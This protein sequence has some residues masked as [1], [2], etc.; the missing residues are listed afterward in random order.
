MPFWFGFFFSRVLFS[1]IIFI[2]WGFDSHLETTQSLFVPVHLPGRRTGGA[3]LKKEGENKRPGSAIS[4]GEEEEQR[5]AGGPNPCTG[6]HRTVSEAGIRRRVRS[7]C[8]GNGI[9]RAVYPS[10]LFGKA[11]SFH[12]RNRL[13]HISAG[14]C[15]NL[16]QGVDAPRP[17]HAAPYNSVERSIPSDPKRPTSHTKPTPEQPTKIW[18][19]SSSGPNFTCTTNSQVFLALD[20]K[21]C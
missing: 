6:G 9:E 18:L 17:L 10:V 8:P 16:G 11:Q 20:F 4:K 12:L 3:A 7:L 15:S 1:Q 19:Q 13:R 2:P 21:P 5:G 14:N